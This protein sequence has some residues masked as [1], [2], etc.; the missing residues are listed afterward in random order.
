MRQGGQAAADRRRA[1][2][3]GRHGLAVRGCTQ[4]FI[5]VHGTPPSLLRRDG[6][7]LKSVASGCSCSVCRCRC[8]Q[9]P[10]ACKL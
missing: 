7:S 3:E 6:L 10:H 2:E 1:E 8:A 4:P 9:W 5:S